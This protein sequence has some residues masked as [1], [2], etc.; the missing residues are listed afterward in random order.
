M[1]H[2]HEL[3][4]E[5]VAKLQAEVLIGVRFLFTGDIESDRSRFFETSTFIR[6]FH[7]AQSATADDRIAVTCEKLGDGL[8]GLIVWTIRLDTWGAEN[9]DAVANIRELVESFGELA[10]DSEH[11]P[12]FAAFEIF[13]HKICPGIEVNGVLKEALIKFF[14]RPVLSR[15]EGSVLCLS[16][17]S[18]RTA[19]Y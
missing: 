4:R 8:R 19:S 3:A 10:D 14:N 11:A 7:D 6:G 5:K 18:G 13:N 15:V 2:E 17:T 16:K 12:R 9:R 1:F